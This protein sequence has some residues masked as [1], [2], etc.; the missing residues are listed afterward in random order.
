MYS[1]GH[2]NEAPCM[3]RKKFN[4]D[5]IEMI[6]KMKS[7]QIT[8]KEMGEVLKALPNTVRTAYRRAILPEIEAVGVPVVFMQDNAPCHKAKVVTEFLAR[9]NIETLPWP[10]QSPDMNPIENLWAIIKRR[11][12]K[13]FS[14]PRTRDELIEQVFT[15]WNGIGPELYEILSDSIFHR[16]YEVSRRNGLQTK[17]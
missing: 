12:K 1:V 13:K 9:E 6:F 7:L 11:I 10:P 4:S 14:T 17:F 2:Q 3:A 16:M 15:I 8:W 5:E